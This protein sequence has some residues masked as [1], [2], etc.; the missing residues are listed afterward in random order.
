VPGEINWIQVLRVEREDEMAE[1]ALILAQ[2]DY[3]YIRT[4]GME[5]V[6][7]RDF[8]RNMGLTRPKRFLSMKP[9][10]KPWD[11]R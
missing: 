10:L 11:G 1:M 7:G 8:D 9:G 3:D 5:I 4:M 6:K 2:T